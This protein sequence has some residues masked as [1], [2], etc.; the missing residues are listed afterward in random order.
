M[1][2]MWCKHL[3]NPFEY[4]VQTLEVN[5]YANNMGRVLNFVD[6]FVAL[7]HNWD[8][9]TKVWHYSTIGMEQFKVWFRSTIK[10]A[11]PRCYTIID[12]WDGTINVWGFSS[13]L[14]WHNCNVSFIT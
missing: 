6:V 1:A 11:Q 2:S 10:M 12:S 7:F 8:G 13:Q 3:H 9:T 5:K 14:G 4:F